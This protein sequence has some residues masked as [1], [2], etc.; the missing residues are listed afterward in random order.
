[1]KTPQYEKF[2]NFLISLRQQAGIKQQS[3]L[4]KALN[5]S[6]QTISRWER[7]LSRPKAQ[8]IDSI[9]L[10]F[11]TLFKGLNAHSLEKFTH[12]PASLTT[13]GPQ[14]Y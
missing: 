10:S 3:E 11:E 1:M 9:A 7:G 5:T 13:H 4:S 8:N 14:R 6:Q 2:G 12:T